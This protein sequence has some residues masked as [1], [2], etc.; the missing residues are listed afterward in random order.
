MR[1]Q[2]GVKHELRSPLP[3][4]AMGKRRFVGRR[5]SPLRR[6]TADAE[7]AEK[8]VTPRRPPRLSPVTHRKSLILR[9][10]FLGYYALGTSLKPSSVALRFR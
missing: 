5:R 8:R 9:G 1:R 10:V 4:S 7:F 2:R 3:Q 6:H